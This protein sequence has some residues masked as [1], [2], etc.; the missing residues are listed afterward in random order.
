MRGGKGGYRSRGIGEE[1]EECL[2][3]VGGRRQGD[4]WERRAGRGMVGVCEW[5]EAGGLLGKEAKG[6]WE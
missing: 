4:W 5:E 6:W 1:A 2:E 3:C